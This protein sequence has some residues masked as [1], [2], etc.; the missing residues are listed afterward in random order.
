MEL[1]KTLLEPRWRTAEV[2]ERRL[3]DNMSWFSHAHPRL[4]SSFERA[5]LQ[6]DDRLTG[7]QLLLG[8]LSDVSLALLRPESL[9]TR[10]S[11]LCL[12]LRKKNPRLRKW[13]KAITR[14]RKTE[15]E[16][17]KYKIHSQELLEK[18]CSEEQFL[19]LK[20]LQ[21]H[22]NTPKI[23]YQTCKTENQQLKLN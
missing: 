10:I 17:E 20:Q 1:Q 5:V 14:Q 9:G 7:L 15:Q 4:S 6:A 12:R 21:F 3:F 23:N 16:E 13:R 19:W 8:E 11:G 22:E 2:Q 18:I